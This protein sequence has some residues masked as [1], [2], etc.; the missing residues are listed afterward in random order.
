MHKYPA[1]AFLP[2]LFLLPAAAPPDLA[3]W[4][5]EAARVT[6]TRDDWGIAHVHGPTDADAVF[7]MIY[8]Q[9]ED[10]FARIEANYLTALGR[11]AEADGEQAIWQD[12]RARLYVSEAELRED[13]ARS[14]VRMQR[15]MDAWADGLNYFLAT[16]P[17]V[18]PRVL[19]R[20]E[21]WM[22]LSFT[23]GSIGG[24]IERID[25]DALKDFYSSNRHPERVSG[26]ISSPAH[27][28]PEWMLKH[29][30]HDGGSNGIAIA[31]SLTTAGKAL[32]LINPHTSFFFRSEAQVSSDEGLN[33]YGA[34]T[35]GQF[36]V[37]Q[38]FNPH[39]GWMHTSSG[40]DNVD[41][42]AETV[43]RRGKGFC[44]RYGSE[45]RPLAPRPVTIRYRAADG[46]L[47]TRGFTTWRSHHGPI[48][49][50]S[51]GRWIAFSMMDRPV[52][53]LQQ[54]YLRTKA[55]DLASYMQVAQLKANSSNNTIFA[56]DKGEI[57]YLHPQFVPRRS[58]SFDYTR[59]VD[60]SNPVTDWGSLH[61]LPELPNVM[62]PPT[63]WVQN[64]N[65]WPYKAAGEFSADPKRFPRYMDMF[66]ENWRGVHALRLL[67]RS[68]DWTLEKLNAAAFDSYQ[69]GFADLVPPLIKA[70][71]DLPKADPRRTQLAAPIALLR[72]WDYRWAADSTAQ[73]LAMFWG[74]ALHSALA[75][76]AD[77]PGNKVYMRLAAATTPAQKLQ[78]LDAAVAR[79]QH[80]FGRWKVPWGEINRF[81]RISPAIDHPFSDAAPSLAVPFA[82][83]V[84]GSLASFTASPKPGTKRW[85]G[86]AG[87]SFVAVVEFG[88]RVRA[89]A[90]TAGG[91]SGDPASKHFNDEAGRYASGALRDVYFYPDQLNGH[92]ER[93]YHPGE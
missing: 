85:Y 91:E 86:T 19:K 42:F 88:P 46:K 92:T 37:Y 45:C 40:V 24:D 1:T 22:A 43:E 61:S 79:L 76:P 9:A 90:V 49:R 38:G 66:G 4:K 52:E 70:Y 55:T 2:F 80:D 51:N 18:K 60:G 48:V 5:A 44:Y 7:G 26:A 23:E 30:Q 29:V 89:R 67:M 73:S 21:P 87:N 72:D 33:V 11:T 75:A 12:L 27:R 25:L 71:D 15:L 39:A 59:P 28:A 53:A 65:T 56:D 14:P 58:G 6:I 84:Y 20:F 68:R 13:Y 83:G 78:A 32:L 17:G 34:T 69:P 50:S 74:D 8:A 31:P 3:R 82:W 10:D 62:N 41:E 57:A 47:A 64:T 36:F 81:Q 93:E 16:H 77:E 35:W 54:S 63:G